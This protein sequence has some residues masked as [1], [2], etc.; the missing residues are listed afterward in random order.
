[1][2]RDGTLS[3]WFRSTVRRRADAIALEVGPERISYGLL[4]ELAG[5][6]GALV[7]ATWARP[8]AVGLCCA[9]SVA[10]YAGY[11][12]VLRVGAAVVPLSPRAPAGR[13]LAICRAAKVE[14]VVCDDAGASGSP[15]GLRTV[16]LAGPRWWRDAGPG[17]PTA[18]H[19][20]RPDD[21]AY[22]LFTSGSTGRPKGVPIRHRQ[23]A[24]YLALCVRRYEVGPQSRLSQTFD[25]TFDPSV[26]DMFV[27]WCAGGTVV[28]PRP[29]DVLL[30]AGFVVGRRLSH[31]FSVPS[32]ISVARRLRGLQPNCMPDLRWSLFAGEQLTLDQARAWAAAA[33]ASV[34]E[35]LYGPTELT[36]TCTSYRLPGRVERW[37]STTNG[38]VPIGRP[39]PHL[40]IMVLAGDGELCVRGPQRFEGYLDPADDAGRFVRSEDGAHWYRTGDRVQ[41][42][43]GELVHLGRTDDQIKI[44][45]FRIEPGEVE[46]VLREHAGVDEA[47]VLAVDGAAGQPELRAFYTGRRSPERELIEHARR[48][49]PDH[50]VPARLVHV[51]ELPTSAN[52][53]LDRTRLRR[54][55]HE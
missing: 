55:L 52:G 11:L 39:Y 12:G 3:T 45:G 43:G 30:P 8:S 38:T 46:C 20:G 48:R 33:P 36:I 41:W 29:E 32:V 10:A 40:E 37:P 18:A 25:L 44:G 31:W 47:V 51:H 17:P 24:A 2:N 21:V 19:Q 7:T 53:K 23:L 42:Q 28:V 27:A 1:M 15:P 34:V 49:L 50:L 6:V 54:G 5:R 14:V 35:N 16:H 26:F 22:I 4:D 9:R 13:N